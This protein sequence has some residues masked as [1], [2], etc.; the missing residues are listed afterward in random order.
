MASLVCPFDNECNCGDGC[1][2]E[3]HMRMIDEYYYNIVA[4]VLAAAYKSVVRLPVNALK[5]FWSEELDRLKDAA[6][7]WHN[8]WSAAGKP[9]AGQLFNIRCAAKLKYKMAIRD[10]YIEFEHKHDDEIYKHFLNKRPCEFW[11]SWN[12]KFRRN[13]NKN[14]VIEG[15]QSDHDIANKFAQHFASVYQQQVS[16]GSNSSVVHA[17]IVVLWSGAR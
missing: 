15:C 8:I 2:N 9:R 1:N 10:A 17:A 5:P 13:I 16:N 3:V 14:V 12:A 6:I 11:K 4:C 7:A